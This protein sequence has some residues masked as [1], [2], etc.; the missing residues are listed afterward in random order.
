MRS[1]LP[2]LF[3]GIHDLFPDWKNE[4]KGIIDWTYK[5][6]GNKEYG[7]YKVEVMNEQ[8]AYRV[9][10]N[11][12]SSR[13]ASVE[14]MYTKLIRRYNIQNQCNPHFKLGYIYGGIRR[15]EPLYP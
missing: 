12:H 14:L 9:P 7:K 10:G 1:L 13:Q 4:V 8:T 15:T 3:S 6:L 2:C 11:S 5:E